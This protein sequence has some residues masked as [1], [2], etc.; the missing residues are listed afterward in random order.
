[1]GTED[2]VV[3]E[4]HGSSGS[5]KTVMASVIVLTLILGGTVTRRNFVS[6]YPFVK[7]CE[8]ELQ[9]GIKYV[10]HKFSF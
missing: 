4:E 6:H 10:V 1:V 3:F 8:F 9:M 5:D 7:Y 2:D